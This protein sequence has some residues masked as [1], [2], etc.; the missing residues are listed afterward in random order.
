M[1]LS[2]TVGFFLISGSTLILE[3]LISRVMSA[4]AFYHFAFLAVCLALFGMTVGSVV[5]YLNKDFF[6]E[7]FENVLSVSAVAFALTIFLNVIIIGNKSIYYPTH[8]WELQ[9]N[10]TNLFVVFITIGMPFVFSGIC[11]ALIFNQ[12]A[13]TANKIYFLNLFASGLGCLLFIPLIN[14]IEPLNTLLLLSLC[15][16]LTA[17]LFLPAEGNGEF[18]S[19]LV[20]TMLLVIFSLLFIINRQENLF[21]LKWNKGELDNAIYKKWNSYSYIRLMD[22][23]LSKPMGWGLAPTKRDEIDEVKIHQI[24]LDIDGLAGTTITEFDGDPQKV[25]FLRYDITALPYYLINNGEVL[26]IGVGGGRDI[27]TALIFDQKSITGVEINEGILRI[28]NNLLVN[29]D[30]NLGKNPRIKF[31]RDEARSHLNS[32]LKKYDVIQISLIDTFAATLAGAYALTENNLYTQEAFETYIE[33]LTENGILSISYWFHPNEPEY[34]LKLTGAATRALSKLGIVSPRDHIVIVHKNGLNKSGQ[35]VANLLVMKGQITAERL[36]MIK[37]FVQE[38]GFDVIMSPEIV[39]DQEF[40]NMSDLKLI[41]TFSNQYPRNIVPTTDD[42]P[43]FFLLDKVSLIKFL[44]NAKL[45][46]LSPAYILF[47]MLFIMSLLTFLFILLP[48]VQS[49][50]LEISPKNL[51]SFGTYFSAIGLAFMFLEMAQITRLSSFLGHPIYGLSIALFS[52][53]ISSGVGSYYLGKIEEKQKLFFTF[54]AFL[55]LSIVL[56]IVTGGLLA[57][58]SKYT[59]LI[60]ILLSILLIIPLGFFMGAFLPQGIRLLNKNKGPVAL[61]WGLN[62]AMSVIGSILAMLSQIMYGIK[63]TF[64][65]GIIFYAIAAGV[66]IYIY[67]NQKVTT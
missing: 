4:I 9:Y 37:A 58:F 13:E 17:Y 65:I 24:Y 55:F 36:S 3:L 53:L 14:H 7:N 59:I 57:H 27:I 29:F 38:M 16:L 2:A 15:G 61:F 54:I 10:Y 50:R 47:T 52:F 41:K 63:A 8:T 42:K 31:V 5:V 25:K 67:C 23:G 56:L 40:V 44:K 26:I 49:A 34:I 18:F 33:H 28:L 21:T 45:I 62:G 20:I 6:T 35:G 12:L 60:R 22:Y 19:K 51:L 32:S 64:L 1:S 66:F 48:L 43:F 11:L 30:G 39:V 46:D